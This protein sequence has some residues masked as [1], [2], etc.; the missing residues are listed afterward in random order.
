M[1]ATISKTAPDEIRNRGPRQSGTDRPT[2]NCPHCS[3]RAMQFF[4]L[5]PEDS[6]SPER[7]NSFVCF[8]CGQSWKM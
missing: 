3:Q 7:T 4:R 6:Q 8:A 2:Y 5:L 1:P